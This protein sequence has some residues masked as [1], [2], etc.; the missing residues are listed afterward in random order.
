[1]N[2]KE[3]NIV[4]RN[5][6]R[7]LGLC[8]KWYEEWDLNS[9][10]ELLIEKYIKGIDFCI[11][12]DYPKL[13]FIKAVVPGQ[14]LADNGIFADSSVVRS[15]M[16]T[17]VLLGKSNGIIRYDGLG[18]GNVYLRH[19]SELTLEVSGGARVFVEV[20]DDCRLNVV[21][22]GMAKV[23]V[24]WHGGK[25]NASGNVTIRDKRKAES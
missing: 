12:N 15:N 18:M 4:L 19:Q 22:T 17:A 7:D 9:P 1:M 14:I 25:V 16:K 10:K 5:R 24:Y 21:A 23:F 13:D 3:L 11:K 20:Y 2:N 8:D 6:A